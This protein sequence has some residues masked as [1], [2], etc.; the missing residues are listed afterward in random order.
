[1]ENIEEFGAIFRETD[2]LK[3]HIR[4]TQSES[5]LEN[6]S[7]NIR[8]SEIGLLDQKIRVVKVGPIKVKISETL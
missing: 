1:M 5:S 3:D 8:N 4:P 2:D 7:N 6:I